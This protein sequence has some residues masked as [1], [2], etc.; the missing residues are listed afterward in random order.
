MEYIK[1]DCSPIRFI[2]IETILDI[3]GKKVFFSQED[4]QEDHPKMD[5]LMNKNSSGVKMSVIEF[6][7]KESLAS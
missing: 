7:S 4:P 1:N 6:M 2:Q 3:A 5:I